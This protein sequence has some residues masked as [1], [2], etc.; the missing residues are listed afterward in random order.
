MSR[1]HR[2]HFPVC[3]GTRRD[4]DSFAP[5]SKNGKWT[6]GSG[7]W[8]GNEQEAKGLITSEGMK[9]YS[10]AAPLAE[11]FSN[12]DKDLIVQVS[13]SGLFAG[14]ALAADANTRG[15]AYWCGV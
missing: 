1:R 5:R 12:K 11:T 9:F 2:L 10:I 6:W 14:C 4:D 3:S 15:I 13:F 8:F 7:E